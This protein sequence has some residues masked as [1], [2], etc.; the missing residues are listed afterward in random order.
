MVL[1]MMVVMVRHNDEQQ[2]N[3]DDDGGMVP[4]DLKD[5]FW[6]LCIPSLSSSESLEL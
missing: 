5:A 3:N 6:N 2:R 1:T 4:W